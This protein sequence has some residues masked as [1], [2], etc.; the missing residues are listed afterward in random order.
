[1]ILR[2]A[3]FR[4]VWI[5]LRLFTYKSRGTCGVESV[6]L[7]KSAR[8]AGVC[9]F[10]TIRL[11]NRVLIYITNGSCLRPVSLSIVRLSSVYIAA[12]SHSSVFG[13]WRKIVRLFDASHPRDFLLLQRQAIQHHV[14]VSLSVCLS[15]TLVD[16][17]HT[18]QQKV[19]MGTWQDRSSVS[20]LPACW[21]QPA[22]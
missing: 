18:A 8:P 7:S 19:E 15:V 22:S 4:T 13:T 11:Y 16:C 9:P 12:A 5:V 10:I 20:W 21:T 6:D 2:R 3:M 1:M 14:S 17:D